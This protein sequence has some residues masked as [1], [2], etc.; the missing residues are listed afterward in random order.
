VLTM[1]CLTAKL[2]RGFSNFMTFL[3]DFPEDSCQFGS[4]GAGL[5]S[6]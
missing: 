4:Y 1:I 2:S 5:G 6:E 3:W